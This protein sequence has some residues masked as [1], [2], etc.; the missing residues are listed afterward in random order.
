MSYARR[1]DQFLTLLPEQE[2]K[3]N[4]MLSTYFVRA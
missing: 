4:K 1:S 3:H 2:Y